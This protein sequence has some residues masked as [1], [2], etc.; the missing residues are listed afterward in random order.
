M[1]QL[2]RRTD[3][4]GKRQTTRRTVCDQLRDAIR[5]SGKTHYRIGKDAEI[6]PEIVARFVRG[7]RDITGQTF[8][9]LAAALGLTLVPAAESMHSKREGV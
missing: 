6:K 8:A 3:Y 5:E 1:K 4:M 9:K 7:E 2:C